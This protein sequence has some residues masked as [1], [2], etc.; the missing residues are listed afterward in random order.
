[1]IATARVA[2]EGIAEEEKAVLNQITEILYAADVSVDAVLLCVLRVSQTSRQRTMLTIN[3]ASNTLKAR[4]KPIC[5]RTRS[6]RRKRLSRQHCSVAIGPWK[7]DLLESRI[8]VSKPY[9]P[10]LLST[11]LILL[12]LFCL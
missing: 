3:R 1:M 12:S 4:K 8:W 5:W 2:V 7:C 9:D 10:H 6:F 11:G